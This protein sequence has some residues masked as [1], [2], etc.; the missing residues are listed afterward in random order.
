MIEDAI[1]QE[2]WPTARRLIRAALRREPE[3]HWLLTRLGLTYYE[4][5]NY[6]RALVSDHQ[7]YQLAPRCPLVLWIWL[8]LIRC[9]NALPSLAAFIANLSLAAFR[10]SLPTL[11]ERV[12]RGHAGL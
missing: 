8:A 2:D 7:A 9:L 6:E 4:E 3:S 12:L 5:H 10:P 1:Q 11:V